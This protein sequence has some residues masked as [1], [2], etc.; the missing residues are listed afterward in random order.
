M[1]QP[2]SFDELINAWRRLSD[3]YLATFRE[4]LEM[5]AAAFTSGPAGRSGP[6]ANA[7]DRSKTETNGAQGAASATGEAPPDLAGRL[8]A[9]EE[10][11][12]RL[13]QA[14][15]AL[16]ESGFDDDDE[17]DG[18]EARLDALEER[19]EKLRKKIRRR[20]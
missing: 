4:A 5:G 20:S 12:R 6:D 3:E 16:V 10:R 1:T 15:A 9:L 8:D 14:V 18:L 7:G 11:V 13:E 2:K 19:L 17:D